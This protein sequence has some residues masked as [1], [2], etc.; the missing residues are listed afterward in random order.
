MLR[1]A[2]ISCLVVGMLAVGI[3]LGTSGDSTTAADAPGSGIPI[4][5]TDFN[6][7]LEREVS[8]IQD[9]L[10]GNPNKAALS[11]ARTQAV[12][13]AAYARYTQ[14]PDAELRATLCDAALKLA[15]TIRAG[16]LDDARQ[17]AAALTT[18]KANAAAKFPTGSLMK[19]SKSDISDVMHQFAFTS[20]GGLGID[21]TL[22]KMTA[23]KGELPGDL[24]NDDLIWMAYQSAVTGELIK[25]YDPEESQKL[26]M[27]NAEAMRQLGIELVG[28]TK[29]KEGGAAH[30]VVYKLTIACSRC[31]QKFRD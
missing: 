7:I 2:R 24:L 17:Q 26:W 20:A 10:K 19:A 18:L 21:G 16:K 23:I 11:K 28:T 30:S 31:H 27:E 1:L 25:G 13:I 22:K 29:R 15:D 3:W 5:T 6:K 12:M 14:G 8:I 4:D 9:A